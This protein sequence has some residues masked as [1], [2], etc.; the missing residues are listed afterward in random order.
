MTIR[1]TEESVGLHI[2]KHLKSQLISYIPR[3]YVHVLYM[4]FSQL[5]PKVQRTL[6]CP[7]LNMWGYG[8]TCQSKAL[9]IQNCKTSDVL[10]PMTIQQHRNKGKLLGSV[11]TKHFTRVACTS[12]ACAIDACA[13][14]ACTSYACAMNAGARDACVSDTYASRNTTHCDF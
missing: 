10:K 6:R 4:I 2:Q 3:M 11:H 1:K 13:F 8:I 5:R 7:R 9:K 12:D 14:D